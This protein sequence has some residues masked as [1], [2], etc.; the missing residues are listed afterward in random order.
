VWKK[1][2][3]GVGIKA[4]RS[5][6]DPR[7]GVKQRLCWLEHADGYSPQIYDQLAAVYRR[8]GHDSDAVTVAIAKQRQRRHA[9]NRP[10]K[11]WNS[12][13]RW[14]ICYGY[15]TWWAGVWLFGLLFVGCVVFGRAYPDHMTPTTRP[16]EPSSHFQP[17][18]YALDTLLPVVDLHQQNNWVPNGFAEWWAWASILAGWILTAAVAA[19]LTGLIKKE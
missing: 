2:Q 7:S 13:L 8:A 4:K 15:R 5:R 11:V 12:L 18:I 9:L 16:G 19:S 6:A 10:G 1:I 14:T 3:P 17:L